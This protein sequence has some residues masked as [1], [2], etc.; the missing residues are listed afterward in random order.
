[1]RHVIIFVHG[2]GE[3]VTACPEGFSEA[4]RSA[5]AASVHRR[6]GTPPPDDALVWDDVYW[7]D[8]TQPDQEGLKRR[9][10]IHGRLREFLVGSLGDVVAY[11]TLPYP[12]DKYGA[13]QE[14]FTQAVE[15][16][17][18]LAQ[19]GTEVWLTVIAHSLGTV[20]ASDGIYN[21]QKSGQFP[22]RMVFGNFFTLGSPIA[23]YG[24]RYGLDRFTKPLRPKVWINAAFPQDLIGY[25]LKPLNDAYAE[26]VT[27]DLRLTPGG[28]TCWGRA[29]EQA[30]LACIPYL[31]AL[32]SHSW[33]FTDRRVIGR[34]A[35]TLAEQWYNGRQ[36]SQ[37]QGN[38]AEATEPRRPR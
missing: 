19:E 11:S 6:A 29:V 12:P 13:I 18:Q 8:V 21:L 24:L 14:R 15:R 35:D 38:S 32:L 37:A 7:A 5:F 25:P 34:I 1:M 2:I 31:G 22:E 3:Q 9:L 17:G 27:E 16:A 36:G 4:V 30:V 10:G 26:A 23:L 28:G 20:I 33:Y